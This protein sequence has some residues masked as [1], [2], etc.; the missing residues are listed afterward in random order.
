MHDLKKRY[1]N[2]P[3]KTDVSSYL[4]VTEALFES[5]DKT[6]TGNRME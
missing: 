1:A 5:V 6:C 4:N 2:S 3:E